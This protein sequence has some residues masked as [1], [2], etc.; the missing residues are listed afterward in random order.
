MPS[1]RAWVACLMLLAACH[2]SSGVGQGAAQ[3]SDVPVKPIVFLPAPFSDVKLGM[4]QAELE[5]AYAPVENISKCE[6]QLV[7]AVAPL[8]PQV[9]GADKKAQS[10]C[11]RHAEIGAPTDKEALQ[12]GLAS[13]E[14]STDDLADLLDGGLLTVA[15][16][17]GAIRAGAVSEAA[18]LEAD[19]GR[20]STAVG[21]VSD[22]T[23]ALF[24]G[25]LTFARARTSRREVCALIAD[26]CDDVEP[27][28][29]RKYT[30]GGYSLGQIDADAHSRVVNG[31][32]RA[33]YLQ[34]EK[35]LA[36][37]LVRRTG[38]LSG[39]GLARASRP[40][41]ELKPDTPS[42][43]SV[44]SSR[45]G[46][47]S[48]P[49]KF[50]VMVANALPATELYWRGAVALVPASG[51]SGAESSW[52][53]AVVW[54]RDGHVVRALVNPLHEETL[55]DLPQLLQATYGSPGTT[56]GAVTTWSLASGVT[57]TL[58]IGAAESL[59]VE[60]NAD[61][62]TPVS[63]GQA[64]AS[65]TPSGSASSTGGTPTLNVDSLPKAGVRAPSAPA[66]VPLP[67]TQAPVANA[68]RIKQC[69]TALR[70]QASGMGASN[71]ARVVLDLAGQ[72]DLVAAQ[73]AGGVAPSMAPF[74]QLLQRQSVLPACA[75]L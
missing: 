40:D 48:A 58:D 33:L 34:H 62:N 14:A 21:A 13:K 2:H 12:L 1:S 4:S 51:D 63:G 66:S 29:V 16:V 15:Q 70:T 42:T 25:G 26:S 59:V 55:G 6:P 69:C 74:R 64:A 60:N 38:G 36:R 27:E 32:C 54:L 73:V 57:A 52:F 65:S 72:C 46:L 5:A 39:I 41:R 67:A 37:S 7:G 43:F 22:V 53:R 9:P 19:K 45:S 24:R 8:P 68:A 31:K 3:D 23:D 71:N 11:A 10:R 28:R 17:R 20:S 75:G 35:A 47:D 30:Q 56:R 50:G 49:A 18:V 44:Y 61:H